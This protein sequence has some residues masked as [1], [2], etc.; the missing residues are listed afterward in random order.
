MESFNISSVCRDD[1]KAAFPHISVRKIEAIPDHEMK[2]LSEKLGSDYCNQLFWDS[3]KVLIIDCDC[4]PS[5][6]K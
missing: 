5:L 6:F 4:C 2:Y 1:I 3:L